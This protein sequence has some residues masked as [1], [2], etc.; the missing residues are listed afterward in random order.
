MLKEIKPEIR[1]IG[2]DDAPFSF[3]DRSTIVIGVV[4]RAGLQV[5][6]IITTKIKVDGTDATNK[7]TRAIKKSKHYG[8]LRIIMLDGITFGGF[9][10]V[11]IKTLFKKTG[12]PV[13]AVI[14]EKPNLASVKKA[15][16]RFKDREKRWKKIQYAGKIHQMFVKNNVLKSQKTVYYQMAGLKKPLAEAI[17][18]SAAVHSGTPEP[19]RIAHLIGEG[20][21]QVRI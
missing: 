7:I 18:K 14:K 21:K 2:W 20:V 13:I 9:N 3:S 17:I 5:D 15:L 12:I 1:I 4:C 19:L 10:I 11:N 8:Q 16:R 6:G